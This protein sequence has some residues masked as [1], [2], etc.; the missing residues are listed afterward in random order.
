MR[1]P[2]SAGARA[3]IG[4]AAAGILFTAGLMLT[5]SE[6]GAID[7]GGWT[8]LVAFGLF[9]C[10]PYIALALFARRITGRA[11]GWAVLAIALLITLPAAALYVLGFFIQPDAQSGLLFLFVP[12]Y[13]FVAGLAAA[14]IAAIA[15]RLVRARVR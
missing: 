15:L 9:A 14:L 1:E 2:T 3:A 8:V 13:Q 4:V 10:S 5:V 6:P 7:A 12:F 11:E